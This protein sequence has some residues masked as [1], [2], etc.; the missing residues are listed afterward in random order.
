MK[1]REEKKGRFWFV[2]LLCA[3]IVGFVV[4]LTLGK[5]PVTLKDIPA[6]FSHLVF[7]TEATY[8]H[9]VET[10]LYKVR[11]PRLL[12]CVFAGVALSVSG[13]A[14]QGVF[15]NPMVSP[16]LLGASSGAAFG[17]CCAILISASTLVMHITAFAFGVGAV[18]L[19][20]VVSSAISRKTR[21]TIT[22]VLT[23]MV[24][25]ALFNAGVSITKTLA[26]TDDK[27]G[28]ITFWLMGSMTHMR[29]D[30]ILILIIPVLV[31]VIPLLAFSYRLNL[32]SF[33]DEEARTMGVNVKAMRLLFIF[34]ATLATSASVAAC[35]MVGWIGLVIPHFMRL[36]VGP[37]YH[38]LLPATALAGGLFLLLVDNITRIFF[39]VEVAIGILTAIIGAPVFLVLLVQRRDGWL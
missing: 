39:Q 2:V 28:E 20:Y 30:T 16:D 27:L 12:C 21:S 13:G 15:R 9:A 33:G 8:E 31:G 17:A 29:P 3:L 14:Y 10:A 36:L 25:S 19:T 1:N 38:R 37:D 32:L 34:C 5:Y 11:L 18:A 22:L 6:V 23:G 26:D 24:V 7:G 35:G 4:S